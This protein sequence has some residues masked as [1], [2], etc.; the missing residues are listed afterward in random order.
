MAL[1]EEEYRDL[2]QSVRQALR[3]AGFGSIDERVLSDL[4]HSQGP[5]GSFYDLTM[6][7]KR[8]IAEISLGS[9]VQLAAV[10]RRVRQAADTE[11]G[12]P[13]A[14]FR[15]E[16]SPEEA[17]RYRTESFDFAPA[18]GIQEAVSELHAVLE[19]LDSDWHQPDR[20]G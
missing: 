6:Y 11:S 16:L 9:D 17:R 1:T 5:Q 2:L 18:P 13:I 14:G 20:R 12:G 8:L 10:L 3:R 4:R 19:E 15:V 7:L